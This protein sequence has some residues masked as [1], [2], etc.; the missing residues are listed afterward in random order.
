MFRDKATA[1]RHF[2]L[3]AAFG[4]LLA[5]GVLFFRQ[6]IALA[7]FVAFLGLSAIT[8]AESQID[9]MQ[10]HTLRSFGQLLR[11]HSQVSTL[12]KMCDIASYFC[13][14]AAIISWLVER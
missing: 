2:H 4:A 1:F 9:V 8:M 14:A 3:A 13:L 12:A 5:S 7:F 10:K 6:Q 11:G